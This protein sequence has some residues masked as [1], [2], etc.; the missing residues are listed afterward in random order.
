MFAYCNNNS[1][2]CSDPTGTIPFADGIF[3][4]AFRETG[5]LIYEFLTKRKH[6]ERQADEMNDDIIAMQN[7]IISDSTKKLSDYFLRCYN[8]SQGNA[9]LENQL[10]TDFWYSDTAKSAVTSA[11]ISGGLA[12]LI[13]A[14][15]LAITG[16][17]SWPV[18]VGTITISYFSGATQGFVGDLIGKALQKMKT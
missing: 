11:Q 4:E 8:I 7:K 14:T 5:K 13:T 6:P 15:H 3:D 17:A 12:V 16:G 9:L 18:A 1:I 2:N 10:V